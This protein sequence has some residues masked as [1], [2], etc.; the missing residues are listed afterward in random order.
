M[1][2]ITDQI[3]KEEYVEFFKQY[4]NA[5]I[6]QNY[7]WKGVKEGEGWTFTYLGVYD[8][9]KLV[10]VAALLKRTIKKIFKMAYIAR[11]PV[12]MIDNSEYMQYFIDNVKQFVQD[13]TFL[14]FDVNCLESSSLL[15][16][17]Q[18]VNEYAKIID[19][20]F[21]KSGYTK[22]ASEHMSDTIQPR[23]NANIYITEESC[24]LKSYNSKL[25]SS[26][27]IKNKPYLSFENVDEKNLDDFIDCINDTEK[28]QGIHL[29][30]RDYFLKMMQS[31]PDN[32]LLT[33]TKLN[34]KTAV[35][36]TKENIAQL[37]NEIENAPKRQVKALQSRLKKQNELLEFFEEKLA[38]ADTETVYI[39]G[40]MV[41]ISGK[42]AEGLYA[43]NK[44]EFINIRAMNALYFYQIQ[45]C[46]DLGLKVFGLGGID[47]SLSDGLYRFKKKFNPHVDI[48]LG[49]YDFVIKPMK[50]KLFNFLLNV[51]KKMK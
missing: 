32:Y 48:Y 24:D 14:K 7:D 42:V 29:R 5:N 8:D 50:Y 18:S 36:Y 44:S 51:R 19:T 12:G 39:N 43:G 33:L 38:A 21:K 27:S 23:Y 15:G 22:V 35:E 16:N 31:M 45:Q 49:E 20:T 1:L 30:N 6:L 41:L 37:E 3:N 10:L 46:Y 34:L 13:C 9:D 25:R 4:D 28:R 17:D 40:Q 2:R 11:G 26:L 47:N